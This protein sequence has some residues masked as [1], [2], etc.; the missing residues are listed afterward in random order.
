MLCLPYQE[1]ALLSL[2][3]GVETEYSVTE[4]SVQTNLVK[5]TPVCLWSFP[6]L[7]LLVHLIYKHLGF[8]SSLGLH[9]LVD[10]YMYMKR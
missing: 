8:A 4:Y 6:P 7:P 9:F 1:E 3:P 2:E 10:A 5:I